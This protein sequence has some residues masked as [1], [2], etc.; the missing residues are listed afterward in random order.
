MS[1]SS[2]MINYLSDIKN[3]ICTYHYN[4]N[5]IP[6]IILSKHRK[7][8]RF[9]NNFLSEF[10]EHIMICDVPYHDRI[11]K[12]GWMWVP[13]VAAICEHIT[14]TISDYNIMLKSGIDI[15][16][17][18][19]VLVARKVK[20]NKHILLTSSMYGN[21]NT[22]LFLMDHIRPPN[23]VLVTACKTKSYNIIEKYINKKLHITQ[24]TLIRIINIRYNNNLL[25]YLIYSGVII[26]PKGLV[27]LIKKNNGYTVD[28]LCMYTHTQYLDQRHFDAAFDH[29]PD[30][31]TYI[32]T[33]LVDNGYNL[34]PTDQLRIDKLNQTTQHGFDNNE[35]STSSDDNDD[36]DTDDN[37]YYNSLTEY[38]Q[39]MRRKRFLKYNH[40]RQTPKPNTNTNTTNTHKLNEIK[41]TFTHH[42]FPKTTHHPNP[43]KKYHLT[44]EANLLFQPLTKT[45]TPIEMRRLLIH[46]IKKFSLCTSNL[47]IP[48]FPFRKTFNIDKN[49]FVKFSD[50]NNL[51][52]ICFKK[53]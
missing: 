47:V 41:K 21:P 8:K 36:T 43:K 7:N 13:C 45:V 32:V 28:K 51:V 53:N 52:H 49:K 12:N 9:S 27:T 14:P 4:C 24:K 22:T 3:S 48:K 25:L 19:T 17:I 1:S 11:Y 34:S 29:T 35:S 6:N 30:A 16:N 38:H 40:H 2:R 18:L 15:N 39:H 20:L 42:I 31:T 37:E 50:L 23:E 5:H 10:L 33:K 46:Y 26:P 44:D